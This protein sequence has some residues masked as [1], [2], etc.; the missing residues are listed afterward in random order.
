MG[1]LIAV[2]AVWNV[3]NVKEDLIQMLQKSAMG[4]APEKVHSA[5]ILAKFK[6]AL[7]FKTT[8]YFGDN[9]IALQNSISFP[10]LKSLY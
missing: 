6:T 4:G 1:K 8:C 3:D 7:F 2:N 5:S 10:I 9:F